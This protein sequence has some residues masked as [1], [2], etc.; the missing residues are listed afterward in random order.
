MNEPFI[1]KN[2]NNIIENEIPLYIQEELYARINQSIIMADNYLKN[3]RPIGLLNN[4]IRINSYKID[5]YEELIIKDNFEPNEFAIVAMYSD[6]DMWFV[7]KTCDNLVQYY[8]F[9][10]EDS[11]SEASLFSLFIKGYTQNT[12]FERLGKIYNKNEQQPV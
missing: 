8:H 2:N 1:I 12:I 5:M 6:R 3:N 7:R 10:N 4:M 11:F 9:T